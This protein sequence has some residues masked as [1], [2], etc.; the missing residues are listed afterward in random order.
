MEQQIYIIKFEDIS[1]AEADRYASE[2]RDILLD[3][4]PDVRIDRMRD[5]PQTQDLGATLALILGTP[6]VTA[7]AVAMG[8]WLKLRN[9]A[10]LT[11]EKDGR[12]I[13]KNITSKDAARLTELFL[14]NKREKS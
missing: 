9:S 8:N 13:A 7:I 5:N 3:A 2:L 1:I 12:V 4:T 10:S 14:A 11:I 6:A